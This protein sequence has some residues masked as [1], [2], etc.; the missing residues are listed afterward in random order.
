M[1]VEIAGALL[2]VF[3]EMRAIYLGRRVEIDM[4]C[5]RPFSSGWNAIVA[6]CVLLPT[7]GSLPHAG[8][9]VK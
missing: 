1:C 2:F 7:C 9:R 3:K 5:E 6:P 4:G 8:G